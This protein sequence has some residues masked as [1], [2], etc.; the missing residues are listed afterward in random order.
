MLVRSS[1]LRQAEVDLEAQRFRADQAVKDVR[2]ARARADSAERKLLARSAN[3]QDSLV[4]TKVIVHTKAGSIEG[5][6]VGSYVD[7]VVMRHSRYL[8]PSN[9]TTIVDL[10]GDQVIPRGNIEWIQA[11]PPS[12]D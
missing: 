9:E 8:D 4:R 6:L 1:R 12:A 11:L 10:D 5:V 7:T 2:R 3:Y